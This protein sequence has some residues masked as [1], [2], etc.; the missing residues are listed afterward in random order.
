MHFYQVIRYRLIDRCSS[1]I[2]ASSGT[3][4][5]FSIISFAIANKVELAPAEFSKIS[6]RRWG[7][8]RQLL[9]CSHVLEKI[10][11]QITQRVK[12]NNHS[13]FFFRAINIVAPTVLNELSPGDSGWGG[14]WYLYTR[15][16]CVFLGEKK[17]VVKRTRVSANLSVNWTD[18]IHTHRV[19]AVCPFKA[20]HPSQIR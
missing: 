7:K 9:V 16:W 8:P 11:Q 20:C 4:T 18:W 17:Y 1:P 5:Y 13:E 15:V 19:L 2:D 6:P 3:F 14:G 12:P 10:F